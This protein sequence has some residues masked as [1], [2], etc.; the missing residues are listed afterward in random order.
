M[1]TVFAVDLGC[2]M[3]QFSTKYAESRANHGLENFGDSLYP[4]GK[5]GRHVGT[6]TPDLYRVNEVNNLKPLL[7]LLFCIPRTSKHLENTLFLVTNW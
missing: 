3:G 5:N 1:M 6:R 2:R 4:Y 7:V